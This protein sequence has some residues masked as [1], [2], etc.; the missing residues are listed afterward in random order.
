MLSSFEVFFLLSFQ[1]FSV[2]IVFCFC[3]SILISNIIDWNNHTQING[4]LNRE[5][6]PPI[7]PQT[8]HETHD[9]KAAWVSVRLLY[10]INHNGMN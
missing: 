5:R 1:F 4:N 9:K 2:V 3:L 8:Q 10:L 7:H 6:H